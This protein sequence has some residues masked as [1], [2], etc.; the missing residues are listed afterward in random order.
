MSNKIS[1]SAC[2]N[3]CYIIACNGTTN[4]SFQL[5]HILSGF[6]FPVD[7]VANVVSGSYT[8]PPT[9]DGTGGPLSNEY[10]V[11]IPS[12][13]YSIIAVGIDWGG[14]QQFDFNVNGTNYGTGAYNPGPSI[15]ANVFYTNNGTQVTTI[16]V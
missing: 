3:E 8:E 14:G 5:I 11:A 13:T 16:T 7:V 9:L 2:D 15:N 1:V 6:N 12:G 4:K 10:D